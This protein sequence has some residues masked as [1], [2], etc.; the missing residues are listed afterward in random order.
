[1]RLLYLLF[2]WLFRPAAPAG[3]V[4]SVPRNQ[5][6]PN[7]LTVEVSV[8]ASADPLVNKAT[9][10]YAIDGGPQT[11]LDVTAAP[12]Q[13]TI[14]ET[15]K[16]VVLTSTYTNK[17]GKASAPSTPQP[18]NV[19]DLVPTPAAPSGVSLR[20]VGETPDAPAPTTSAPGSTAVVSG[21]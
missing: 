11:A 13:F 5:E 14:P 4:L 9:A 12:Q 7:V 3:A 8:P 10:S 18:F 19:A 20:F 15:A 6:R 17:Y 2:P 1:M 16:G 21:Q